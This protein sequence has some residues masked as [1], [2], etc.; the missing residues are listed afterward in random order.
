MANAD[1]NNSRGGRGRGIRTCLPPHASELLAAGT[2]ARPK[3]IWCFSERDYYYPET[4]F[5][6]YLARDPEQAIWP[7]HYFARVGLELFHS[8][9]RVHVAG[10][11]GMM[12]T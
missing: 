9:E 3:T 8:P 1:G 7:Y 2:R 11:I 5:T 6:N 4:S 12:V 10:N